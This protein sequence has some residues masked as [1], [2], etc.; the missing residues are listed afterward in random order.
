MFLDF[1]FL[2]Y[3]FS[4]PFPPVPHT[5]HRPPPPPHTATPPPPPYSTPNYTIV[6][7]LTSTLSSI[8]LCLMDKNLSYTQK[9]L[10]L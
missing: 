4:A 10:V 5:G 9:T 6:S 2:F 3:L 7:S 1:Y 8:S